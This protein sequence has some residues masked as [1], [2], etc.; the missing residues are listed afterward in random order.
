V[1]KFAGEVAYQISK[2][3]QIFRILRIDI[4]PLGYENFDFAEI[5]VH[6]NILITIHVMVSIQSLGLNSGVR[7]NTQLLV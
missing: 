6:Y 2:L 7:T 3:K 1:L 4:F 5:S